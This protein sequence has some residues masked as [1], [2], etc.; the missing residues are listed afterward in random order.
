MKRTITSYLTL[1]PD[2][3][4]RSGIRIVKTSHLTPPEL[5]GDEV[6]VRLRMSV[7][8]AVLGLPGTMFDAVADVPTRPCGGHM[9]TSTEP[10]ELIDRLS[11][12]PCPSCG[13]YYSDEQI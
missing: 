13:L 1:A 9:W 4:Q 2:R 3:A 7:S 8:D 11:T 12:E 5:K 10:G 6:A